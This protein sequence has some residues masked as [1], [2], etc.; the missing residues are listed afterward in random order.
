PDEACQFARCAPRDLLRGGGG[1][2]VDAEGLDGFEEEGLCLWGA[3]AEDSGDLLDGEFVGVGEEENQAVLVG[4]IAHSA[5]EVFAGGRG[6]WCSSGEV[7]SE[8]RHC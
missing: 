1:R 5:L 2:E 7:M 6:H 4:E 3:D 8:R